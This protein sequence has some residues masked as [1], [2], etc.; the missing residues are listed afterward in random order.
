MHKRNDDREHQEL[1][2]DYADALRDGV[3]PRFLKSLTHREAKRMVDA[4]EIREAMAMTQVL[5]Q[6][7]FADKAV[8][9]DVG[10]FI[11]RV[12][13][14]IASRARRVKAQSSI[15]HLGS[16]QSS[17]RSGRSGERL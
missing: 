10:L 14:K 12:D 15:R 2:A 17:D 8:M 9:P 7:A 13:A 4:D 5:N 11:S 16:A 1:V 3:V 6:A